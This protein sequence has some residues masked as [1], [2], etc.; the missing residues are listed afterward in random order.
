[1]R[2]QGFFS[3]LLVQLQLMGF[4]GLSKEEMKKEQKEAKEFSKAFRDSVVFE[5]AGLSFEMNDLLPEEDKGQ[6]FNA[7]EAEEQIKKGKVIAQQSDLNMFIQSSQKPESIEQEESFLLIS[8]E[9]IESPEEGLEIT[10]VRSKKI[11]EEERLEICQESGT[12]QVVI[13][14]QRVVEVTPE[15]KSSTR[16]CLGHSDEE[17]YFWESKA[18]DKK[19]SLTKKYSKDKSI[20]TYKIDMSGGG[21]VSNYHVV[22]TYTHKDNQKHC[23]HYYIEEKIEQSKQE[24]ESW[25][26]NLPE[27]LEELQNDPNCNLL[28]SQ[29]LE[30]PATK[31]INGVSIFRDRWVQQL[32]YS[33]EPRGESPCE[34]LRKIGGILIN[35]K[36]V[37]Q[38][39]FGECAKWQKTYDLG[40]KAEYI[41]TGVVFKKDP[42]FGLENYFDHSYEKSGDFGTSIGTLA[43]FSD[44]K[45]TLEESDES[46]DE[47]LAEIFRGDKC[48]C[49]KSI[50]PNELYDC[51][52]KLDG[53]AV[54]GGLA[55]CSSEE[56]C[57][58]KHRS[59]GKCHYVGKEKVKAGLETVHYFCCFPTKLARVLQEQGREQ[60]GIGWGEGSHPKCQGLTLKQFQAIDFSKIDLSEVVEEFQANREELLSKIQST[61]QNF[62][63]TNVDT[64][65]FQ[66]QNTLKRQYEDIQR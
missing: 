13:E 5:G 60:L 3:V 48:K 49:K 12:Y 7:D 41:E 14:Q 61:I 40:K 19:K 57:L 42:I 52:K 4:E 11:K 23:D 20:S 34:R 62:E 10:A 59:E 18:K 56:K 29:V 47:N 17:K 15:I 58:A 24:T 50:A 25:K 39:H 31:M 38:N 46:F 1:M 8:K 66:T 32:I 27:Y 64:Y 45:K 65:Q 6:C 2:C 53:I 43:I 22:G 30:G 44:L 33:C 51:C 35:K 16:H 37:T 28:Y 26:V 21:G 36:C 9:V 63:S 55:H 54:K